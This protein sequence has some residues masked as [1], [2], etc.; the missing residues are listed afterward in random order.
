M[1][2]F[3]F[4]FVRCESGFHLSVKNVDMAIYG[5]IMKCV[6]AQ[7]NLDGDDPRLVT[8]CED[9]ECLHRISK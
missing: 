9:P 8:V 3:E 4:H 2:T 5:K 7:M 6:N 1:N